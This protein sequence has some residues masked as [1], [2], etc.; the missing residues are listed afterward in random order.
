MSPEEWLKCKQGIFNPDEQVESIRP[1]EPLDKPTKI[2]MSKEQYDILKLEKERR[3][4]IG[5]YYNYVRKCRPDFMDTKLH[6]K[7]AGDIQKFLEEPNPENAP[8]G[9]LLISMSFQTGKTSWGAQSGP[10]WAMQRWPGS[11]HII[12]SYNQDFARKASAENKRKIE[13]NMHLFPESEIGNKWTNDEFEVVFD[14]KKNIKSTCL[15]ATMG[16]VNGNP[17]DVL[18][19]DDT[20][21]DST[22][23]NSDT[24][25]NELEN[26]WLSVV[27]SRIKAKTGKVIVMQT[28]WNL[29]D[30]HELIKI[31]EDPTGI[32][33]INIPCECVDPENDYLGREL[34]DGPCP[35]IGKDKKW[36]QA[37]KQAYIRKGNMMTWE[38]NYQGNPTI[39][40]GNLFKQKYFKDCHYG[41][42]TDEG[43]I[44]KTDGKTLIW[45][46][47][48]LSVD[49]ALKHE[50][51]NDF[52]ALQVWA[53]LE[54]DYFILH[55]EAEH[56]SF[57]ELMDAIERLRARFKINFLYI[58]EAANGSAAIDML[59]KAGVQ[60][61]IP[62]KPEGGK[63]SRAMAV[64]WLWSNGYVYCRTDMDWYKDFKENLL[65]F[66][67]A[68][69][70]DPV[71]SMSQALN[72]M[73]MLVA[74]DS[75]VK[76]IIGKE[77]LWT[78]DMID[79]YNHA[80]ALQQ[81][82]L[83]EEWGKPPNEL[84]QYG[85]DLMGD[86]QTQRSYGA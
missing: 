55:A 9:V 63:Y 19:I 68:K 37:F 5:S 84:G 3:E 71:D 35:E 6:R 32:K 27:R 12:I 85:L 72:R 38:N 23:A 1:T 49:A 31:L 22:E 13:W 58:E 26:N 62:V 61:V 82:I 46:I 45:P 69:H 47:I 75:E 50:E 76:E 41:T 8:F 21:R 73:T 33:C 83:R 40:Q 44:R 39:E 59:L 66:P 34:G 56:Y 29:R 86:Y 52:N 15:S 4:T 78:Q 77:I 11:N 30:I 36:V 25:N 65:T 24:F 14:K 42:I 16:T 79:D 70:D 81:K 7:L 28:R 80:N 64:T 74:S 51:K 67:K 10:A 18:W 43:L 54:D 17:A 60:N 57:P 2:R 20:C 53:K 48:V